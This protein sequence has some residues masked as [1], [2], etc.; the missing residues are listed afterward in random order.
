MN[1][2]ARR[3]RWLGIAVVMITYAI[4]ANHTNQSSHDSTLGTLV[5]I[6]PIVL[7]A[8]L[9]AWRSR[10]RISMLVLAVILAGT[11]LWFAW[12]LLKQHYDWI[13]WLEHESLQLILFTTFARTLIANRQPLCSQFA[14]ILQGGPLTP[15]HARYAYKVTVAWTVF[16]AIMIMT[17][18]WLFFMYPIAIW[19]IFSN[20]VF[21]PLVMLMFIME[22]IIRKWTLPDIAHADLMA[23]LRI[24][25][26]NSGHRH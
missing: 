23:A 5:A 17:S 20:F 7:A 15:A 25:L 4:L 16:F 6:A 10:Q 11:S 8:T 1:S 18:T 24:Y 2:T 26:D 13:Y 14:E 12:P 19:S 22:F 9:L 3:L 21:L